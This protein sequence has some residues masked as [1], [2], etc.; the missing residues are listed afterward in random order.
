MRLLLCQHLL[1]LNG[2]DALARRTIGLLCRHQSL[3]NKIVI[4][5]IDIHINAV[6]K[7]VIVIDADAIARLS[8]SV[9]IEYLFKRDWEP[10]F[11]VLL[12]A[13]WEWRKEIAVRGRANPGVKKAAVEL[14]V[15]D[16][17]RNSHLWELFGEKWRE[18]RYYSLIMQPF[19][20]S[21]AINVGDIAVAMK[22]YPDLA[23]EPAMRRM[24][25]FPIFERYVDQDVVVKGK[26]AVRAKTQVIMFTSDISGS[27]HLW[28][29]FGS[30]P[31]ACAGTSMA[32]GLLNAIH[33]KMLGRPG[34][35]PERGHKFSGRNND[36]VTSFA[37]VWYFAKTVLPV[38]AGFGGEKTTEAA[39]LERAAAA[40]LE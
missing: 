2:P 30:G 19:L 23:L 24:H 31:R 22:R 38:V 11:D 28:P 1:S 15:D 32:L 18:P 8:L 6:A 17:I 35:E 39:A 34:F 40:A 5:T 29:A 7:E 33:G 20:V 4:N 37:E 13:S 12:A 14:V 26:V 16:L 25:P 9:F 3:T 21:P 27:K 10:R 36:G